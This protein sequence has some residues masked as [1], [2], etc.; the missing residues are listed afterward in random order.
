MRTLSK[1]GM[2]GLRLGYAAG[3]PA[4]IGEFDKVRPPYNVNVLTQ[5]V[6]ERLLAHAD[7]LE[8]QAATICEERGRLKAALEGLPGVTV[9]A[10][11]ANFLLVRVPDSGKVFDGMKQVKNLH[12]SHPL[13]AQCLRI[14]VGAFEENTQCLDA[15]RKSL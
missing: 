10:S 15:L 6:A 13:L 3:S 11:A 7:V 9:F 5:L 14:T 1:V 2:A 12:G 4:W 8:L